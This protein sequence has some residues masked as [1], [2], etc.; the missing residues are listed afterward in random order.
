M[1]S[2]YQSKND[3]PMHLP[4]GQED[5]MW[6]FFTFISCAAFTFHSA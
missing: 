3:P 5:F 1:Y 2:S 6:L 4:N